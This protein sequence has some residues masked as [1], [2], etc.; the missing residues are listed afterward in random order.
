MP[1]IKS[2]GAANRQSPVIPQKFLALYHRNTKIGMR[3]DERDNNNNSIITLGS[4]YSSNAC[5][6]K[7]MP[8]TN[9]LN[10]T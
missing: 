3:S 7:Q 6:A 8:E 10:Q 9:N 5:E 2:I 4:T 1:L